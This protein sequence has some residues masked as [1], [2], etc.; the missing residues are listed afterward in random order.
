MLLSL[1]LSFTW[2][3]IL[4][5]NISLCSPSLEEVL[6]PS[7]SQHEEE[8]WCFWK[9]TV[10]VLRAGKWGCPIADDKDTCPGRPPV[11]V[12]PQRFLS[13]QILE[14]QAIVTEHFLLLPLTGDCVPGQC[15]SV[16]FKSKK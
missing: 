14:G 11:C 5:Y 13:P 4:V 3:V 16:L 9:F 7:S 15:H 12:F 10:R 6:P 2:Y 8:T 1:F